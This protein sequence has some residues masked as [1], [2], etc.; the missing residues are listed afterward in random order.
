MA[1]AMRLLTSIAPTGTISLFAGNVS[2]GIEPIFALSYMR[3]VLLP[4][5]SHRQEP[6]ED[7]AVRLYRALHGKELPC[8][9]A[10][11]PPS[12][13]TPS[14]HLRMQAAVQAPCRLFDFEDRQLSRP[15]IGFEDF[16]A[17]Y[18]RSL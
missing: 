1:Y 7:Y 2:S 8:R 4:D 9:R 11:S 18:E 15:R 13:L 17:V 12:D 3:K 6:V 10:S 5:G 14:D 16:K